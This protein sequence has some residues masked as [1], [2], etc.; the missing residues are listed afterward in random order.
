MEIRITRDP[1]EFTALAGTHL[2]SDPLSTNVV[3]T[4]VAGILEGTRPH[5]IDDLWLAIVDESRVVGVAMHTPPFNLF[6]SRMP[7]T[8]AP[9]LAAYLYGAGHF[10]P[11]VNGEAVAATAFA[12]RWTSLTGRGWTVQVSMRLYALGTLRPPSGVAGAARTA[13]PED[14]EQVSAWW[15]DFHAEAAPHQPVE[16][17]TLLGQRRLASG[18]IRLWVEDGVATALAG[19]SP[20][21]NGVGR[22]GPV[23]TPPERRRSGYGSAVTAAASQALLDAGADRVVLYTDLANPVSNSIYMDIGYVADHDA[24]H[25][26]FE[27]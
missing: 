13:G 18:E 4:Y 10:V 19:L 6:V 22:I 3:G 12:D 5:G 2:E 7:A 1:G 16:E 14:I 17:L 23:Y 26:R 25:C 20:P 8:A 9:E 24:R 15:A 11:G 27:D 21:A